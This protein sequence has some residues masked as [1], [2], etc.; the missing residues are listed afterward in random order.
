MRIISFY[1]NP[2]E[3]LLSKVGLRVTWD[4]GRPDVVVILYISGK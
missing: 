2:K 3:N 4:P 1:R